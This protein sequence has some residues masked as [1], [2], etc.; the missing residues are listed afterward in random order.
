MILNVRRSH[1][2]IVVPSH[3][4]GKNNPAREIKYNPDKEKW[5]VKP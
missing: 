4:P 1:K 3:Q 2:G 5:Y